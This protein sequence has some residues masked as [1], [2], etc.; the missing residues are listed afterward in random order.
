[1]VFSSLNDRED[2][3]H[4]DI[5]LVEKSEIFVTQGSIFYRMLPIDGVPYPRAYMLS[6]GQHASP[7]FDKI[8]F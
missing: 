8:S 1:M 2:G 4:T 5:V 3:E 6:S 7:S